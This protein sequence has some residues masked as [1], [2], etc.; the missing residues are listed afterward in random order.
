MNIYSIV[1]RFSGKVLFGVVLF[2]LTAPVCCNPLG[3]VITLTEYN[4]GSVVLVKRGQRFEIVLK[5]NPTTGHEWQVVSFNKNT[6]KQGATSFDQQENKYGAGGVTI[7][8]FKTMME[9]ET[10]LKIGYIRP[11]DKNHKFE[12]LFQ[13]VIKVYK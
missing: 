8:Q 11:F 13:V 9:G 4:S 2:L 3:P 1:S 7:F 10:D 5:A 12:R 6:L